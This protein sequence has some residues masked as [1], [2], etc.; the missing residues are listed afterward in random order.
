[1]QDLKGEA[2]D[3]N[4]FSSITARIDIHETKKHAN[5]CADPSLLSL[6]HLRRIQ[7]VNIVE[8]TI[9]DKFRLG[10]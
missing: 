10:F 5:I 2:T 4:I 6:G 9:K 1:M 3:T 7:L 8:G